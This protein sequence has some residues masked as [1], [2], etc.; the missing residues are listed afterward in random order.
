MCHGISGG[1]VDQSLGGD[2]GDR[3]GREGQPLQY[4]GRRLLL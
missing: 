4:L 3:H 2:L 1:I